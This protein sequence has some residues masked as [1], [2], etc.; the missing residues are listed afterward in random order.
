MDERGA[1]RLGLLAAALALLALSGP[2]GAEPRDRDAIRETHAAARE[3]YDRKDYD[4]F[5]LHSRRLVGLVPRSTRARY[6]LACAQSLTGDRAGALASLDRLA[7]W[8]VTF[9]LTAE[10]RPP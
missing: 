3:A 4:A 7:D 9:D 8:E 10:K 5:L 6:N 2:S 1:R